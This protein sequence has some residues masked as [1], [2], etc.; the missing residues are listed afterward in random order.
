MFDPVTQAIRELKLPMPWNNPYD[1]AYARGE[2]WTGSMSNDH[3]TRLFPATGEF[4]QYLL[5]RPTNIRRVFL[6]DR[7]ARPVL[8]I[9][10]NHGA[11]V[12]RVEP[13]D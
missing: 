1:V 6:D 11:S 2:A 5:P 9:G 13:L 3:V 12:I 4:V 10:S 8:W 7:S